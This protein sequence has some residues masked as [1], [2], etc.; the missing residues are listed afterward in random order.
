MARSPNVSRG[1]LGAHHGCISRLEKAAEAELAFARD[2]LARA[3]PAKDARRAELEGEVKAR[4][5]TL[6]ELLASFEVRRARGRREARG[7]ACPFSP[8]LP[9]SLTLNRVVRAVLTSPH[10]HATMPRADVFLIALP[11][12]PLP[13]KPPPPPPTPLSP[14]PLSP[15]APPNPPP[16]VPAQKMAMEKQSAGGGGGARRGAEWGGAGAVARGGGHAH[17]ATKSYGGGFGGRREREAHGGE[18]GGAG[19]YGDAWGGEEEGGEVA[20]AVEARFTTVARWGTSPGSAPTPPLA[21]GRTQG[22][23]A[24]GGAEGGAG[25]GEAGATTAGRRGTSHASAPKAPRTA[26]PPASAAGTAEAGAGTAGAAAAMG[27]VGV[28]GGMVAMAVGMGPEG[29]AMGEGMGGM[30]W[31]GDRGGMMTRQE[32]G[33]GAM[34]VAGGTIE[35]RFGVSW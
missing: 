8:L 27:M 32:G 4:E 1:D 24:A 17:A 18:H 30:R 15:R 5:A 34:A 31:E 25:A 16:P 28:V 26:D 33:D 10:H 2:R 12:S 22:G 13:P 9:H 11:A 7:L 35:R 20:A 6:Q 3:P 19:S 14:F 21:Q 29:G 23:T